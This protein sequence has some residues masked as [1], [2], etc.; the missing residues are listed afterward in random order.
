M[1]ALNNRIVNRSHR[2]RLSDI[3]VGG[4]KVRAG[5]LTVTWLS[6]VIATVTLAVG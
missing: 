1:I 2:Y 3:P 5:K 4:V 6:G